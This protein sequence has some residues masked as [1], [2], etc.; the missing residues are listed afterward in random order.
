MTSGRCPPESNSILAMTE[1][2]GVWTG[3]DRHIALSR[4]AATALRR[5]GELAE[6]RGDA[7]ITPA[8]LLLGMLVRP[9]GGATRLLERF[10]VSAT[11]LAAVTVALLPTPAP[12]RRPEPASASPALAACLRLARSEA[13][14][15]GARRVTSEH[16]LLGVLRDGDGMVALTLR[17][18]GL[19]V[20]GVRSVMRTAP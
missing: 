3:A 5:A 11:R 14:L 12:R 7:W 17:D 4:E 20:E 13:A 16:L 18:Q 6:D 9:R 8:H 1:L 10:D 2:A 19:T 15:A